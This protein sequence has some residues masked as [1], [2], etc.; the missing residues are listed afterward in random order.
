MS[1]GAAMKPGN[2]P[3]VAR[4][5]EE[6]RLAE[7]L[8]RLTGDVPR[9]AEGVAAAIDGLLASQLIDHEYH[10][11]QND[12]ALTAENDRVALPRQLAAHSAF[13]CRLRLVIERL[14]EALDRELVV[15][16]EPAPLQRSGRQDRR[17]REWAR[18]D[19]GAAAVPGPGSFTSWAASA[20]CRG[21]RRGT[22]IG[23]RARR[24]ATGTVR[25]AAGTVCRARAPRSGSEPWRTP[26]RRSPRPR[27]AGR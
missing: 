19:S 18:P 7:H 17:E 9:S 11:I 25:G 4:E 1:S 22:L 14:L 5:R 21:R 24:L 15:D 2:A 6:I 26:A 13:E 16:L 20:C 27:A 3:L 23:A 10:L 8:D 12:A